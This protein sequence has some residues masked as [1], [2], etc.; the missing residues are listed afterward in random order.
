MMNRPN[1]NE[2][3]R[4][5]TVGE[6]ED[7]AFRGLELPESLNYADTLMFLM[8]RNLY[9]FAKR[10]RMESAQGKREKQRILDACKRYSLDRLY[11]Q[12]QAELNMK[13]EQA[14]TAYR[15]NPSLENADALIL[16][17]DNVPVK[18][19]WDDQPGGK[20]KREGN[21]EN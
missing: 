20:A 14:K 7:M 17:L 15:K 12:Y 8:F 16:A 18:R 2:P 5:Y 6:I 19:Y 4:E 21:G 13:T 1:T 11:A 3:K 10:T 9:D